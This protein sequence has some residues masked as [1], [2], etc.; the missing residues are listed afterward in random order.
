MIYVEAGLLSDLQ[1]LPL[2]I[3]GGAVFYGVLKFLM[4][5]RRTL[6]TLVV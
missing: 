3:S 6:V 1:K 5:N 2:Q 4:I